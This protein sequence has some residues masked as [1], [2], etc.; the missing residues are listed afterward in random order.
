[1]IQM[2]FVDEYEKIGDNL[3]NCNIL[4]NNASKSII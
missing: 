2:I 4:T 3:I 1:M